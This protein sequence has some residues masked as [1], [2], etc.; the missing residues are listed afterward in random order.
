MLRPE[1]VSDL[2]GDGVHCLRVV[3]DVDVGP[4]G[5]A[6]PLADPVEVA[7]AID[8]LNVPGHEEVDQAVVGPPPHSSDRVK[9]DLQSN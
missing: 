3:V 2:V 6:A 8:A 5:V 4:G 1:V 7:E 9:D